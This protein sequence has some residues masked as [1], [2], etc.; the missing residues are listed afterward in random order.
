[1]KLLDRLETMTK[2]TPHAQLIKFHFSGKLANQTIRYSDEHVTIPVEHQMSKRDEAFQILPLNIV[3]MG[4]KHHR[5]IIESLD[6]SGVLLIVL[7]SLFFSEMN[8]TMAQWHNGTMAQW[9]NGTMAQWHNGTMAQW[10]NG[11]MVHWHTGTMAH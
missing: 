5:S 3:E 9:H 10:H 1:M 6:V 8:G 7:I 11:T 2:G 4:G